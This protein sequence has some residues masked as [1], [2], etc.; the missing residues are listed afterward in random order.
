[1]N[2]AKTP[3]RSAPRGGALLVAAAQFAILAAGATRAA[4]GEVLVRPPFTLPSSAAAHDFALAADHELSVLIYREAT[5]GQRIVGRVAD[6]RALPG[7]FSA[8]LAISGT[9]PTER[10]LQRDSIQVV[11]NRALAV[12]AEDV[13]GVADTRLI[14]ARFDGAN[15]SP[16][17]EVPLPGIATDR[18]VKDFAVAMRQGPSGQP[19][20]AIA[21]SLGSGAGLNPR[22]YVVTSADG[23]A[24]WRAPVPVSSAGAKP[25]GPTTLSIGGVDVEL[26]PSALHVTWTDDRAMPGVARAAFHRRAFLDWNGNA[27]F[28][29]PLGSGNETLLSGA[30]DVVGDPIVAANPY[31]GATGGDQRNVG[32]AYRQLDKGPT[33]ATLAVRAS[34]DD[35][36]TFA[37]PA[38]V[39][40]TSMP[41]VAVDEFD[42]GIVG[43][44][45][46]VTWQDNVK[47]DSQGGV[48]VLVPPS[49]RVWR[50]VSPDGT[51]F[52]LGS[53]ASV[54]PLAAPLAADAIRRSPRLATA[55]GAPDGAVITFLEDRGQG[56]EVAAAFAD[57]AFA[58][59]WHLD[60][61]ARIA[62]PPPAGTL[63]DVRPPVP[64]FDARYSNFIVAWQQESAPET[65]DFELVHG[66]FRPLTCRI[67]GFAPGSTSISFSVD[68]APPQDTLAIV[69]LAFTG[70]ASG[71]FPLPDGRDT[72]L[73]PDAILA[74]SLAN[75][76]L[77]AA[78]IDPVT[79]TAATT[80]IPV[81]SALFAPG[82]KLAAAAITLGGGEN[83]VH[84]VSDVTSAEILP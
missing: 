67:H 55:R 15:W 7:S 57:Q 68:H 5:P 62:P 47:A 24:S 8:P 51:A 37:F 35:G 33:A 59:K 19:L 40:H 74:V 76:V 49:P 17:L 50:A 31:P 1:M 29:A 21:L 44:S 73:F 11:A 27:F 61:V 6:G 54:A 70:I 43:A 26:G 45:Y 18:D 77:F 42:F 12:W 3:L 23:G 84:L 16:P 38:T 72:G 2:R 39:A 60:Q 10:R 56:F 48:S 75:L 58:G 22:L 79:E 82:F 14:V 32:V 36:N 63:V 71:G 83:P 65:D 64:A 28:G 9:T 69:L 46:V 53:G 13:N 25:G 30:A 41:G 80:V 66:G 20:A 34:H 52:D 81:P 4:G 78:P